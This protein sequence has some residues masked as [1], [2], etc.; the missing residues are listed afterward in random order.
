MAHQPKPISLLK[1]PLASGFGGMC[2]LFLGH[3]LDTVKVR[4]QTQPPNLPRQPPMYSGTLD[5]LPKTL[6]RGITGLYQGMAAPII[7]IVTP[8][9][10]IKCWLQ[11]QASSGETKYIGTLDCAK[12]LY[13]EFGIRGIYKRTV[14]TL[15]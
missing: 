7:G 8:G 15:M 14:L 12:K 9:A 11:F 13:Q 6:R 4:L 10:P 3:P 5:C 1:N 2:L